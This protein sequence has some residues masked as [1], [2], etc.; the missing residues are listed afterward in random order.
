MTPPTG[1][2]TSSPSVRLD[3]VNEGLLNVVAKLDKIHQELF[4]D[5]LTITSARD[6]QHVAGSLHSLG[7]AVDI[8][9]TDKAL[10]GNMVLLSVLGYLVTR[11]PI[12]VFD[13]RNLPDQAHIHIEWH[14]SAAPVDTYV[15]A[16]PA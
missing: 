9:T 3:G 7:R 12:T 6:G 10:A 5:Q 11:V 16:Q 4:H 2:K 13:E 15:D 8:R 1:F 14:G